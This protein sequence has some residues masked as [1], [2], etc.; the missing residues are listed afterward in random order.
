MDSTNFAAPGAM[1]VT[2]L[3]AQGPVLRTWVIADHDLE[4][5]NVTVVDVTERQ[6]GVRFVTVSHRDRADAGWRADSGA[7][8]AEPTLFY[9][10][11][12]LVLAKVLLQADALAAGTVPVVAQ[13]QVAA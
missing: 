1:C 4:E 13:G 8:S 5:L 9:A 11:E 10:A 12:V 3:P 2:E 6:D 7:A